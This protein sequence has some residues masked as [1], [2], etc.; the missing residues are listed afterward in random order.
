[1]V[2][3]TVNKRFKMA[4]MLLVLAQCTLSFSAMA[5]TSVEKLLTVSG[6]YK[7]VDALPEG[8]KMGMNQAKQQGTPIPDGEFQ[9][10]LQSIDTHIKPADI[11]AELTAKVSKAFNEKEIKTLLGWYESELG[12]EITAAE[13]KAS[14][15]EAYMAMQQ[16]A[17]K[18]FADTKRVEFA[19][20][21]DALVGATDSLIDMQVSS[22]A[23][24]YSAVTSAM[25]P[26]VPQDLSAFKS[27]VAS[28]MAPMR[29]NMEQMIIISL[30]YS[31][32]NTS[33]EK[34]AKYETFLNT[35]AAMKYS[36]VSLSAFFDGFDK[37]I[38]K[39]AGGLASIMKQSAAKGASK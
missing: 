35:P 9:A 17:Q 6:L 33:L 22:G 29:A 26:D 36:K 10:I 3:S 1:M 4:S 32:Q 7:Q 30:V 28:Q 13:A 2:K 5:G 37:S 12:K 39:W 20:R 24:V 25:N 38:E 23:A 16:Q 18:L 11:K 34:L 14:T 21:Y 19:Q 8:I 27:Q 15:P 31:H